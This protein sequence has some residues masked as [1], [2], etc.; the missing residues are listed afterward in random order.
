[1]G[2]LPKTVELTIGA[3]GTLAVFSFLYKENL[4]YRYMEHIYIGLAA[5]HGAVLTFHNQLKPLFLKQIGAQGQY[6]LLI[7][8][9]MGLLLYLR[10]GP[11][12]WVWISRLPMAF[13]VGY[14][15]G[16]TL[17]YDPKVLLGQITGTFLK[18]SAKTVGESI[19]NILFVLICVFTLVY[20]MFT[21]KREGQ[22]MKGIS[23][24]T[25]Y[26]FMVALG[27]GFSN[28]IMARVSLFL[29]RVQFLLGDWLGLVK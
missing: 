5:A 7:P 4:A 3:I 19:N 17:A 23:A 25:R 15:A 14:N 27:V 9:A 12:E 21:L 8:V 10:Y 2:G 6:S 13:W 29:G 26:A 18:F 20:F 1:M 28:G 11:K 16:Y 22:V 24:F